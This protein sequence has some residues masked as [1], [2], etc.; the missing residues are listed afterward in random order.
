MKTNIKKRLVSWLIVVV[1][2]LTIPF[3]ANWPWTGMDYLFG[4]VML[5]GAACVYEL[6]T[7]NVI[8]K[9][10]KIIVGISVFIILTVLWVGAAT[11][12]G[13]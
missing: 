11:G 1:I 3:F 10:K 8:E 6:A 7:R 12:Y 13:S 2:F 5:Y 9:K 4:F